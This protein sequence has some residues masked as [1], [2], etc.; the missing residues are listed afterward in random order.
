MWG[1]RYTMGARAC[2]LGWVFSS[3]L[4]L[5]RAET[6]YSA[7]SRNKYALARQM[8]AAHPERCIDL[9]QQ[10]ALKAYS[11]ELWSAWAG[12]EVA[13]HADPKSRCTGESICSP[14]HPPVFVLLKR[15]GGPGAPN[16][17]A[18]ISQEA[19]GTC[20]KIVLI[21][22]TSYP[23]LFPNGEFDPIGAASILPHEVGH[24][25]HAA[26]V[27]R[28]VSAIPYDETFAD[29]CG[30][31]LVARMGVSVSDFARASCQKFSEPPGQLMR[32]G[33]PIH[34]L[35]AGRCSKTLSELAVTG[36]VHGSGG[37]RH[38]RSVSF[39]NGLPESVPGSRACTEFQAAAV[40]DAC[41]QCVAG[42]TATARRAFCS[43]R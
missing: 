14:E 10:E 43:G 37:C 28:Q 36:E 21:A 2:L 7:E 32:P 16:A 12:E 8:C 26:C 25:L 5:A 19:D 42:S 35:Q 27:P 18:T 33:F 9:R 41:A 24:H 23:L 30:A 22:G 17:S 29:L 20:V 40:L 34:E 1:D 38:R 13:P 6:P 31:D 3:L 15:A 39:Q 11:R 4:G